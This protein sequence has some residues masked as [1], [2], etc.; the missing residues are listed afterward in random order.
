MER[1]DPYRQS[2]LFFRYGAG[3]ALLLAAAVWAV[4]HFRADGLINGLFENL[5][6]YLPNYLVHEFSHRLW[7]PLGAVWWCYMSGSAAEV[8]VPL[9]AYLLLMQLRGG[10]WLSPFALYW[11]S[12]ALYSAGRYVA[13]A[14]ASALALTSSDMLSNYAPGEM[15]GDW[16]YILE[17]LGL[18]QWDVFIGALLMIAAAFCLVMTFYS[19]WYYVAHSDD[20]LKQENETVW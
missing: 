2:F 1:L 18:L 10:R 15:K 13:D 14:R 12:T 8:G 3:S 6:V 4:F 5:L 17:P 20:F 16:H 9:A 19:L 7:C 11:L